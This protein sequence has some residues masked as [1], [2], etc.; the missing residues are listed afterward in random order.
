ME[1]P[2]STC[3]I[4]GCKLPP[5]GAKRAVS[6]NWRIIAVLTGWAVKD[7]HECRDRMASLTLNAAAETALPSCT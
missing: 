6:S 5:D 4:Q 3:T 2:E 1:A 7:R